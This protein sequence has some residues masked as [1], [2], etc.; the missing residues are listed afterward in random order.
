VVHAHHLDERTFQLVTH[1]KRRHIA[2]PIQ[3]PLVLE[4]WLSQ[5]CCSL[6]AF[7]FFLVFLELAQ[8]YNRFISCSSTLAKFPLSSGLKHQLGPALGHEQLV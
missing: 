7:L 5:S 8:I 3:T 4:V 2:T 1:G 6:S